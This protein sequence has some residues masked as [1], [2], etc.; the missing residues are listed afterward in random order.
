MTLFQTTR[1]YYHIIL[2]GIFYVTILQS[3]TLTAASFEKLDVSEEPAG[4]ASSP[5]VGGASAAEA[6]GAFLTSVPTIAVG[7]EALY[8]RFLEGRLEYRPT[9]GSDAGLVVLFMGDLL[10]PLAGTTNPLSATFD[11]SQCGD[12][13]KHLSINIGYKKAK[14][15][16]N[17]GK[18]E[19]WICPKFL[20]EQE[21]P[22]SLAPIMGKWETPVGYFWTWGEEA[23]SSGSYYYLLRG[24]A[25]DQEK[26]LYEK[27]LPSIARG[28]MDTDAIRHADAS[29]LYANFHINLINLS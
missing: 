14:V 15:L 7:H 16:A 12:T 19:V 27:W 6:I 11:L 18:T 17:E 4:V 5:V 28:I 24:I 10:R 13:W 21:S 29:I 1:P 26:N 3:S 25:M 23:I 20:A 2:T 8:R 22:S 9:P